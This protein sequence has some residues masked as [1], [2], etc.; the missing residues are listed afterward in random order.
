LA[1]TTD[2]AEPLQSSPCLPLCEDQ[3]IWL[4]VIVTTPSGPLLADLAAAHSMIIA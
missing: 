3:R 2:A 4:I 1:Q